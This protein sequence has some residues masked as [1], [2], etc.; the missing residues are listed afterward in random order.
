[1]EQAPTPPDE[2]PEPGRRPEPELEGWTEARAQCPAGQDARF[3][4]RQ[5]ALRW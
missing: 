5:G 2:L 3:R 4:S 1:M